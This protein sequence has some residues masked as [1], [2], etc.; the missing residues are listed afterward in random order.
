MAIFDAIIEEERG[1]DEN[2]G[3]APITAWDIAQGITAVA[4]TE[5][6]H[7]VRFDLEVEAKKILDK[8]A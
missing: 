5:L 1:G 3:S 7:D 6:N 4:R 2:L 8:V